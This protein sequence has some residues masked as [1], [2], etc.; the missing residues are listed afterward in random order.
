MAFYYCLLFF[1]F[2]THSKAINI[3]KR[4]EMSIFWRQKKAQSFQWGAKLKMSMMMMMKKKKSSPQQK[5]NKA[6]IKRDLTVKFIAEFFNRNLAQVSAKVEYKST[7][8]ENYV[9]IPLLL[10]WLI[11]VNISYATECEISSNRLELALSFSTTTRNLNLVY[12]LLMTLW[13]EW[14]PHQTPTGSWESET[15]AG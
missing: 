6:S 1:F 4:V 7:S 8:S 13:L 14:K 9:S 3:I 15:S 10:M 2:A 11:F 12:V 5:A